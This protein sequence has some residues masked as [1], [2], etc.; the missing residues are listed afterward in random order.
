MFQDKYDLHIAEMQ[1][2][3]YMY[4]DQTDGFDSHEIL[5][6]T[7]SIRNKR[8]GKSGLC[9]TDL[10]NLYCSHTLSTDVD[11]SSNFRPHHAQQ[12]SAW[13]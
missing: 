5:L 10:L 13:S 3:L 8:L 7:A 1:S 4:T 9:S 2:H 12:M 6:L 11:E